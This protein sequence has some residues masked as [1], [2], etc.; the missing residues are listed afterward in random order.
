VRG[1]TREHRCTG[2]TSA[3][4][5]LAGLRR[6]ARVESCRAQMIGDRPSTTPGAV[7]HVPAGRVE[8]TVKSI[9]YTPPDIPRRSLYN[10]TCHRVQWTR[11]GK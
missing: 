8:A 10:F 9:A 2:L 3:A 5:E 1:R 6:D 4:L 11:V 7:G